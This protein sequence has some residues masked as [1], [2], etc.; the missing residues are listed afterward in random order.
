MV[1]YFEVHYEVT[2]C[3]RLSDMKTLFKNY[4]TYIIILQAEILSIN[5]QKTP[6]TKVTGVLVIILNQIAVN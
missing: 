3:R 6:I 4:I 1:L 2:N 5:L